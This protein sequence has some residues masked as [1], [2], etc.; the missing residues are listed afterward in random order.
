MNELT[1]KIAALENSKK[2]YEEKL[3][4]LDHQNEELKSNLKRENDNKERDQLERKRTEH[5]QLTTIRQKDQEIDQLNA[6]IQESTAVNQSLKNENSILHKEVDVHLSEA[7]LKSSKYLENSQLIVQ[8][9]TTIQIL[10]ST[11]VDLSARNKELEEKVIVDPFT[12]DITKNLVCDL[13]KDIESWIGNLTAAENRK[14]ELESELANEQTLAN[15]LQSKL[16]K[17]TEKI[18]VLEKELN[19]FRQGA[20]TTLESSKPGIDIE[21]NVTKQLHLKI[22]SLLE[23][24][25]IKKTNDDVQEKIEISLQN[26]NDVRGK[27][28]KLEEQNEDLKHKMAVFEQNCELVIFCFTVMTL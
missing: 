17:A 9:Q 14:F 15:E 2:S 11:V 23:L 7:H 22:E 8:H 13:E 4:L 27:L 25:K 20:E 18:E 21:S 5:L 3:K 16:S 10:E 12:K 6:A 19:E 28:S 1:C 24:E 26:G